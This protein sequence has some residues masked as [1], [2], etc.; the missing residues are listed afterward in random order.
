MEQTKQELS[1][2]KSVI[3]NSFPDENDL[4]GFLGISKA[5]IIHS[6]SECDALLIKFD[7]Y[8]NRYET[9]ILKR[10]LADIFKKLKKD[11]ETEFV[12]IKPALFDSILN[13]ITK[14]RFL[15]RDTYFVVVDEPIKTELEVIKAKEELVSLTSQI[16]ELKRII[17][18]LDSLKQNT[19]QGID[20]AKKAIDDIQ[21]TTLSDF[22]SIS[23][24]LTLLKTNT[25]NNIIEV[26]EE[27]TALK[28][29][30]V[31]D[32][33][34]TH[35]EI[36]KLKESSI[37]IVDDFVEKQIKSAE[38]EKKI[39]DFLL[40]VE[41]HASEIETIEKNTTT[42]AVEIQSFKDEFL[43][44]S[45]E[46]KGLNKQS[47]TL[48]LEIEATHKKI[49]GSKSADGALIKGYLQETEELKNQIAFFLNEQDKKFQAQFKHIESLLPGATSAGLA[50][51]FEK[52]RKSYKWPILIWSFIFI[53]V[54][55][56]MTAFSVYLFYIQIFKSN[57]TGTETLTQGFISLLKDLPF[58]IPTIWLAVF[59]SKQQSQYKRL[60]QEYVFKEINAKSF[61]GHKRQ[62]EELMKNGVEDNDL[63]LK[64][65]TQLVVITSQNPSET[66]DNKSH[67]DSPPIFAL[68]ERFL[69][70]SKKNK[71]TIE[72]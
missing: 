66:L 17:Q 36:I 21:Q 14:I 15:I 26:N 44:S 53:L 69:P 9:I 39:I 63:L 34:L 71:E 56:A 3:N 65:V 43:T 64:L 28:T 5:L 68:I 32:I 70:S 19:I 27:I 23:E 10:E 59:A 49:F 11:F 50:E 33:E 24:E 62:I 20:N 48:Q 22:N 52:Q 30:T 8:S 46:Y 18:E 38:N 58:F 16:V 72:K 61:Y 67:N 55:I 41:N 1:L 54:T 45:N 13:K 2:L 31:K 47:L 60:Q 29:S 4:K 57:I 42:W 51:A 40:K 6:L 35:T 12:N 37:V 7:E 25:V